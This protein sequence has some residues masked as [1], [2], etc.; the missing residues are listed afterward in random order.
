MKPAARRTTAIA[1]RRGMV[2]SQ[3]AVE[4]SLGSQPARLSGSVQSKVAWTVAR[5]CACLATAWGW[6]TPVGDPPVPGPG[7]SGRSVGYSG[8]S[9]TGSA[10]QHSLPGG[11]AGRWDGRPSWRWTLALPQAREPGDGNGQ[12]C[13][14]V[15]WSCWWLVLG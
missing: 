15:A 1:A 2:F 13:S 6:Y 8:R 12:G 4:R 5:L 3:L 11:G 7:I 14:L 9:C 10:R